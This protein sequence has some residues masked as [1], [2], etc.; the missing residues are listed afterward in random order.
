LIDFNP[1]QL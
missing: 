1:N